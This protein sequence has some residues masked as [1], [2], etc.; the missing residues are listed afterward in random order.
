MLLLA[1][2]LSLFSEMQAVESS[3]ESNS[4]R[5][6]AYGILF[7][8]NNCAQRE[9]GRATLVY[10]VLK[11]V[12][13]RVLLCLNSGV[14]KKRNSYSYN[15][16]KKKILPVSVLKRTFTNITLLLACRLLTEKRIGVR[17]KVQ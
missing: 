6:K 11:K 2:S 13:C 9:I 8:R 12:F 3:V 5:K 14:Q 15:R 4:S 17:S 7:F 1:L 10:G 16:L